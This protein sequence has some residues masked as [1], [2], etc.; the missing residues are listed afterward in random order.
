MPEAASMEA[1]AGARQWRG[2][3]RRLARRLAAAR[4]I[5]TAM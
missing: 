1:S 3:R 5:V 4:R 2:A